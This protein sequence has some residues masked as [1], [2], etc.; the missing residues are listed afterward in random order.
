MP[1]TM[2]RDIMDRRA[3][4]DVFFDHAADA[5]R[6]DPGPLVIQK[7]RLHVAVRFGAVTQKY[8]SGFIEIMH[9]RLQRGLTERN[10]PLLLSFAENTDETRSEVDV[11]QIDV[12]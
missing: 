8:T 10:D 5:P 4:L 2:R 1:Q 6:R 7:A 11:L 3:L 12:D 9:Q